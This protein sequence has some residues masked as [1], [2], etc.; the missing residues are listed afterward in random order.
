MQ[1]KST[2]TSG[3]GGCQLLVFALLQIALWQESRGC[4]RTIT[5]DKEIFVLPLNLAIAGLARSDEITP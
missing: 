1:R 5:N 3:G 4:L 2:N